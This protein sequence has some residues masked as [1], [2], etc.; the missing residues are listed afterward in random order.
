MTGR[1]YDLEMYQNIFSYI[2]YSA[3]TSNIRNKISMLSQNKHRV[4]GL[5]SCMMGGLQNVLAGQRMK[6]VDFVNALLIIAYSD[7]TSHYCTA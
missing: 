4:S 1:L 7:C 2:A 3:L 5:N 6:A